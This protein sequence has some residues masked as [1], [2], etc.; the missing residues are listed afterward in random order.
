MPTGTIQRV[1]PFI[2]IINQACYKCFTEETEEKALQQCSGCHRVSYCGLGMHN[3]FHDSTDPNYLYLLECQKVDWPDHKSICKALKTLENDKAVQAV[4]R[5]SLSDAPSTD[6]K[7][8]DDLSAQQTQNKLR[9][10][11]LNIHKPL[12]IIQRNLVAFEPKC[13]GW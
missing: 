9:F 1:P 13:M 11:M 7:F 8:L 2:A 12:T 3:I 4:L 5:I 6:I 10:L